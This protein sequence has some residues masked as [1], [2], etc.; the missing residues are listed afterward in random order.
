MTDHYFYSSLT[1]IADLEE[2]P[3]ETERIP[4]EQWEAGDYVVGRATVLRGGRN[5]VELA[6]GRLAPAITDDAIIAA[7]GIRH[8]TLEVVGNFQQVGPDGQMD[9]LTAGGLLGKATSVSGMLPSLMR[10][11]YMGHATRES[12][13]LRMQDFGKRSTRG[14]RPYDV[15][16]IL[17]IGT[18]MSAGKT[19]SAKI[20]IRQLKKVGYRVVA[21]KFSGAGRYRDILAMS[22]AGADAI[23]DFVDVGLP[24]SVAPADYYRAHL[25]ELL[26]LVMDEKPDVVVAEAGASPV[27]PYNSDTV[28][29]EIGDAVRCT[30]LCASDPYAVIGVIHGFDIQPDLVAGLATSTVAGVDVVEKLTGI[31]ALNLLDE[32]SGPALREVLSSALRGWTIPPEEP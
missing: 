8:A 30:V 14:T 18:S 3:Y 25:Q 20:I 9:L 7:L 6:N 23:Y 2:R 11:D 26:G 32:R 28:L 19:T 27:E 15:P 29:A 13:K 10:I 1:R 22:D 16:T 12:R 24:S 31:T 21:A 5:E 17:L 4:V